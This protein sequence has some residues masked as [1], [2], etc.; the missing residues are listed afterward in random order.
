MIFTEHSKAAGALLNFIF[1]NED[2]FT[3]DFSKS[4]SLIADKTSVSQG[5]IPPL[6]W[7]SG[8]YMLYAYDIESSKKIMNGLQYPAS[9]SSFRV[10]HGQGMAKCLI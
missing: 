9:S 8:H 7:Y 3:I 2:G 1:I 5:L 10:M 6:T 4:F